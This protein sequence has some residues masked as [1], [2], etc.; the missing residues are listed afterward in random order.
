MTRITP[1]L[2][3]GL[4]FVFATR[5]PAQ[6]APDWDALARESQGILS[7]YL[8]VNTTNPPGNE[9]LAARFLKAILDREGIEAT[10][11]DTAE[12]GPNR[13]NF[14]ARLK[15]NGTKKAI[16]LVHHMDVVP[17]TPQ[18][19]SVDPFS[20]VVKHGYIWGAAPST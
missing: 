18:S 19:W 4:C 7:D 16:A 6:R 13:A 9:I 2:G 12:I 14:Y 11:L 1:A 8:R 20:G 10:I 3:L 5:L 17:V 15:G